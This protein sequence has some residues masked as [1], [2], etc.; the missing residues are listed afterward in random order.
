[1]E[2]AKNDHAG[3]VIDA[4]SEQPSTSTLVVIASNTSISGGETF[5]LRLARHAPS[6][7]APSLFITL[8][9]GNGKLTGL[10]ETLGVRT[11]ALHAPPLSNLAGTLAISRRIAAE[12]SAVGAQA[13]LANGT[14]SF[15]Y[16]ALAGVTVGIPVG[17]W[18]H[19]VPPGRQHPG[20]YQER[21]VHLLR[22]RALMLCNSQFTLQASMELRPRA[23]VLR[24][25]PPG[26]DISKDTPEET[27][28]LK[29]ALGLRPDRVVV[30][31]AGRLARIKGVWHLARAL[32]RCAE[33]ADRAQV[34]LVGGDNLGTEQ[35]T[36]DGVV[37]TITNA[38]FV[39]VRTGHVPDVIPYLRAMDVMVAPSVF[40]E[41][42]GLSVMEAMACA[43]PVIASRIG[44]LPELVRDGVTGWLVEP[45]AIQHAVTDAGERARRG[46]AGQE[47]VR[48]QFS[49]ER[50]VQLFEHAVAG[51]V[52][53]RRVLRGRAR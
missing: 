19:D 49:M 29:K 40:Q 5:L 33:L 28:R 23:A 7:R 17:Q 45:A 34:L 38:G 4:L 18:M 47:R 1:M 39:V 26:Q 6:M 42:F 36:P 14:H 21:L 10:L 32:E 9:F 52:D 22:E 31:F 15:V 37:R 51:V 20:S 13:I 35:D 41:T 11:L 50:M 30:G 48:H 24:L 8:G 2:E 3:L 46:R 53:N 25:A 12:C 16:A 27:T 43:R 44:A